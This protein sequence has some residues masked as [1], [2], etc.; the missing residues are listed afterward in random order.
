MK[1]AGLKKFR[2]FFFA[3]AV[4]GIGQTPFVVR[5][6]LSDA[7]ADHRVLFPFLLALVI[8]VISIGFFLKIWWE[9]RPSAGASMA[10]STATKR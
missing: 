6:A 1:Y 3:L 2:W 10:S 9:T 5:P 8:R 4:I 7:L